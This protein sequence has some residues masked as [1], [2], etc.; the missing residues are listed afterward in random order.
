M[1]LTTK[2]ISK[3]FAGI[4]LPSILT[5]ALFIVS[6]YVFII[7]IFEKS[8]MD[9]KRE[10]L[11]ELINTTWNLIEEYNQDYKSGL[12]SLE[13]AQQLSIKRIEK[14]KYGN[15]NKDYFWIIDMHPRMIMHPY[16]KELNGTDLNSYQDQAGKFLFVDAVKTVQETNEGFIDYIWQ[17][18]DDSSRVVPKLSY[19]K[20]FDDWNWIIG[21]GVYLEDV[22]A[23]I[24]KIKN[25]LN[26]ISLIILM[27]IALIISFIIKQSLNIEQRRKDVEEKLRSSR[28]KY[29][30]LVEASGDG[31]LLIIDNKITFSNAKFNQIFGSSSSYILTLS[32]EDIFEISWSKVKTSIINPGKSE[33]IET[34]I[35][36][37]NKPPKDVIITVSKVFFGKQEGYIIITKDISSIN[38]AE[39]QI[40]QLSGEVQTSL[41]L[42]NQPIKHFVSDLV[43]CDIN[44]S[45]ADAS[46]LMTAKNSDILFITQSEKIV[47]IIC[48]KDIRTRVFSRNLTHEILV[49]EIMTAPVISINEHNLLY[50]AILL[51]NKEKISHLAVKNDLGFYIGVISE[52]D[53]LEMQRNTSSY[54]I[55]EIETSES[56]ETIE[57]VVKKLPILIRALLESGVRAQNITHITTSLTDAITQRIITLSMEKIGKA[58]CK[59]TFIALGSEGRM[60]QTLATDQDN[61]IIFENVPEGNYKTY[62]SYFLELGTMVSDALNKLGFKYCNGKVM[63]SNPQW[64]MNIDEWKNQ[65]KTWIYNPDPKSILEAGIFFDFRTVYGENKLTEELHQHIFDII[66]NKAVFFQHM[67]NPILKFKSVVNLF[68]TITGDTKI[69]DESY[70]DLK[71]I[72]LPIISFIRIYVLQ[73]KIEETNS[74]KRLEKLI[75]LNAISASLG[76][77]IEISYNYLMLMRFKSQTAQLFK[78]IPTN[79]LISISQLSDIEKTTIKKI[80]SEISNLQT[81]INFDFKAGL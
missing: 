56:I 62:K 65:F 40:E 79:N 75:E 60:E 48:D 14:I 11:R 66:E 61:A 50:E 59:F 2:D 73:L 54:L 21:T 71:K 49:S 78:N 74:I 42:M 5:I 41:L 36:P 47:G 9:K 81:K 69:N 18:K 20:K 51:F 38:I 45:L 53:V 28:R 8:I 68:G 17:W 67:A 72:L 19:V 27:I 13:E 23:E 52:K 63:A 16:R 77:E 57:K 22:K 46:R 35:K 3:F 58:P 34:S 29:Q 33:S 37:V 12:I 24:G 15:E 70:I 64:V 44:T 32:F 39:K 26:R 4:V 31:T 6:I 55:R 43:K 1:H 30:S 10:M 7:P 76:T 25:R 80:I